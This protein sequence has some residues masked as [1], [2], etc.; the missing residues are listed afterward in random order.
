[1]DFANENVKYP[2]G[3]D[4]RDLICL[5]D[6][7]EEYNLGPNGG[8]LY[9]A[10]FL[11]TNLQWL[12]DSLEK[13]LLQKKCNYFIF[14]LPGQV[15]LYSNHNAIKEIIKKL[16]KEHNF[17]FVAV[18]LV[19]ISY[20]YDRYRFLSAMMLSLTSLVGMEIPLIN[21]ITKIDL[22]STMGKPD[23]NLM[24]YNGTTSGLKYMFFNEYDQADEAKKLEKTKTKKPN[25]SDRFAKLTQS[26]CELLENYSQVSFTMVDITD[27]MSMTHAILQFD[28]AN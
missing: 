23:M 20:L 6:A 3:I 9:C 25:F 12:S 28:K 13:Q 22:L 16:E 8:I 17:R 10:E 18:H 15:E 11:L 14:D 24:F 5:E 19:D 1:M 21:L 7:M 2:C 27:R 26:L 4:V